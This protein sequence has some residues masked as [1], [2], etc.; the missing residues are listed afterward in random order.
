MG[1]RGASSGQYAG[2]FSS[3]TNEQLKQARSNLEYYINR[4]TETVEGQRY[5]NKVAPGQ[6][7][8]RLKANENSLKEI[9]KQYQELKREYKKRKLK[10]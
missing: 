3:G 1:G 6:F 7:T 10:F 9:K 4:L 5:N 8:E 2:R